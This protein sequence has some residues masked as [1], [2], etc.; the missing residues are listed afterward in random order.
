MSWIKG[1]DYGYRKGY[2]KTTIK[3]YGE[4]IKRF[5]ERYDYTFNVFE[6]LFLVP[7]ELK[8]ALVEYMN[9]NEH[10]M[11]EE[12]IDIY[13]INLG[14]E[15][16][17]DG[18]YKSLCKMFKEELIKISNGEI[19]EENIDEYSTQ[20]LSHYFYDKKPIYGFSPYQYA[21]MVWNDILRLETRILMSEF[22]HLSL[23]HIAKSYKY[24]YKDNHLYAYNNQSDMNNFGGLYDHLFEFLENGK[25]YKIQEL[26]K[27]AEN[28]EDNVEF[29]W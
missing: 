6:S 5:M 17:K 29:E 3:F 8:P 13:N 27:Y 2:F 28:I 14:E 1:F 20:Y 23:E 18:I 21:E 10:F 4:N 22:E 19:N 12:Y 15:K 11:D 25:E 26:L 7:D 9:N 24:I 16:I